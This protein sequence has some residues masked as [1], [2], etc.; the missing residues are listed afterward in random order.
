MIGNTYINKHGATMTVDSHNYELSTK[1]MASMVN[2]TWWNG[3][4]CVMDSVYITEEC[5]WRLVG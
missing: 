5:G 4:K 1:Y 3:H 2:V